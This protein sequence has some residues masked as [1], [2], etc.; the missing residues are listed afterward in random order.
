MT[1]DLDWKLCNNI[2]NI[3]LSIEL[4]NIPHRLRRKTCIEPLDQFGRNRQQ[5]IISFI[6]I[7]HTNCNAPNAPTNDSASLD[8]S[9]PYTTIN[10]DIK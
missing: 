5:E 8:K 4:N 6:I 2:L 9:L 1:C 10:A 3:Q 7:F